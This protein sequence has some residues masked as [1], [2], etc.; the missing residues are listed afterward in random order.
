MA[1]TAHGDNFKDSVLSCYKLNP[2]QIIAV[3]V[4]CIAP[5]AVETLL[6]EIT[7]IP[8]IVYANSGEKYDPNLG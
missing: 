5:H 7:D 2:A 1:V 4:N 6:K 3:G 8:L